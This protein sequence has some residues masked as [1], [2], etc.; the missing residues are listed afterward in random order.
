[1]R[2]RGVRWAILV[3]LLCGCLSITGCEGG[4]GDSEPTG[5]GILT[6]TWKGGF[7]DTKSVNL[8]TGGSVNYDATYKL[9]HEGNIVTGEANGDRL[10]GA[11]DEANRKLTIKVYVD[12][13]KYGSMQWF[14]LDQSGNVLMRTGRYRGNLYRQ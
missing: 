6:G 11:Y 14:D 4:D 7:H 5:S 2:I 10:D 1:M 12:G 13:G 8:T 3:G 9:S